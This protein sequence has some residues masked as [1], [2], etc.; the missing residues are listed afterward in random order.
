MKEHIPPDIITRIQDIISRETGAALKDKA[1]KELENVLADITYTPGILRDEH[2]QRREVTIMLTDLRG[3]T[4]ISDLHP[5]SVIFDLLNQ[6]LIKMSEIIVQHGGTINKFI[7]DSILVLFGAPHSHLDDVRRAVTCAV[8]M[9]IAMDEIISYHHSLGLPEFYMGIGINT[10]TVMAG[11]LGSDLYNEYTVIGNEVNLASR[12][13]A[14][15]LRGQVL[16]SKNT[17][18]LCRDF[19]ETSEPIDVYVKGI[20]Q[21]VQVYEVVSIPSLGK[22]LPR[23]EIRRSHRVEVNIPFTYRLVENKIVSS[24]LRSGM[25]MDI[26]YHGV[27][28]ELDSELPIFSDI[29]LE[30]DLSLIGYTAADIYAKILN[31]KRQDNR[32]LSA[33]EFTSVSVQSNIHIQQFVQLL[34]QGSSIKQP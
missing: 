19:V 16:I 5:A 11:Y 25:I 21:A 33:I 31:S 22:T 27:L 34:V 26:S 15:S 2:I 8:D 4:S 32:Y 24:E 3:F 13:E 9:Q 12:I 23:K 20:S 10:G 1:L 30:I 18:E 29:K 17:Y 7:G 14:F 6:H 28:A